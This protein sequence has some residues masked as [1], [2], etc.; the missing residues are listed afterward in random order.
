MR[1]LPGAPALL[2]L[3]REVLLDD[4]MPLLPAERQPDA[5]LLAKA[6]AIAGRE[7]AGDGGALQAILGD[8]AMFYTNNPQ[9]GEPLR[10]FARDL[11]TGAFEISEQRERDARALL[12]RLTVARL[13][14]SNPEFLAANGFAWPG[15]LS[16]G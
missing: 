1:D 10:R 14:Q 15:R 16:G 4:L 11:R 13:R 12:W 3:A 5:L 2:A 8:L 6:M 9:P 7:A